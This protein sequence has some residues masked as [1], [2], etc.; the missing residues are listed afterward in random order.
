MG[1]YLLTIKTHWN[2]IILNGSVP[3]GEIE[4]MIDNSFMLV[5]NK[6]TKKDQKSILIHL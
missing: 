1:L 3:K 5:V 6:M 2:T 4:R